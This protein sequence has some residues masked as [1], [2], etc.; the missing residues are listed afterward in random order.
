MCDEI[1][2]V[3]PLGFESRQAF[4]D[5]TLRAVQAIKKKVQEEG[6]KDYEL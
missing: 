5:G 3:D 6:L 4:Y 2:R 1:R